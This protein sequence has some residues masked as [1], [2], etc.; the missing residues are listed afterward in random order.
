MR[1]LGWLFLAGLL[2]EDGDGGGFGDGDDFGLAAEIVGCGLIRGGGRSD[3]GGLRLCRFAVVGD[4]Q[5]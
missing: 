5:K 3:G 2:S 4:E 1:A